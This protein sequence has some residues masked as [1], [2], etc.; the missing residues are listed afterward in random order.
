MGK[1]KVHTCMDGLVQNIVCLASSNCNQE[2]TF[3]NSLW[4]IIPPPC[5]CFPLYHFQGAFC[6][7]LNC[8]CS[9]LFCLIFHFLFTTFAWQP[10]LAKTIQGSLH[11]IC[12]INR[13]H[14]RATS[15]RKQNKH[16]N[17]QDGWGTI[18][19]LRLCPDLLIQQDWLPCLL[20]NASF[21]CCSISLRT[22][23]NVVKDRKQPYARKKTHQPFKTGNFRN[24]KL[25]I[26]G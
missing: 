4:K 17:E 18:I 9:L 26:V 1:T 6:S 15:K 13:L 23:N 14:K 11:L 5:F 21:L 8:T 10:F 19:I 2:N 20:G 12:I 25:L 24:W 3:F 16:R 22:T 7:V